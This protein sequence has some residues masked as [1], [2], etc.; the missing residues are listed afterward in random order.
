MKLKELLSTEITKK[1]SYIIILS[2]I[3]LLSVFVVSKFA[4]SPQSY[5]STIQ[6]IDD[7]KSTIAGITAGATTTAALL[8][9]VPGDATTPI[10]N[11]ILQISSY[12]LIVV[13]VLVLEKS[14][15]TVMGYLSFNLLIPIACL[16]LGIYIF[17]K[18]KTLKMLAIKILIFAFVIVAI[19]PFSMKISDLIY[20]MNTTSIE[21]V[22]VTSDESISEEENTTEKP[23]LENAL[24]K[25]KEGI[26]MATDQAKQALNNFIDAVAIFIIVYCAIP[27][28]VVLL[29][30]WFIKFLFKINITVKSQKKIETEV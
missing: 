20:D 30:V 15:L 8:A 9:T 29:T 4:T 12:L 3:S 10:S 26:S 18:N 19:I 11:Q 2:V 25:A 22:T 16:L 21:Q 14:L 17:K 1:I 23:L 5:K 13:C 6:S 24:D 28:V 27:I 7:K